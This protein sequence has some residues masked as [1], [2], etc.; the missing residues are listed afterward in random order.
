[1]S[2]VHTGIHAIH[3]NTTDPN[4]PKKPPPSVPPSGLAIPANNPQAE[5]AK[6]NARMFSI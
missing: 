5:E 2:G 4:D 6:L 3:G 1:M